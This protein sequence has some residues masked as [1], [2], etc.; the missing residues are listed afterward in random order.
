MSLTDIGLALKD[1][2]IFKGDYQSFVV[3]GLHKARLSALTLSDFST[4]GTRGR[5]GSGPDVFE[6]AGVEGQSTH[7][8]LP[9]FSG[10]QYT[11]K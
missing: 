11:S 2:A 9:P 1:D 8:P 5:P 10:E 3:L 4:P 7:C 6:S